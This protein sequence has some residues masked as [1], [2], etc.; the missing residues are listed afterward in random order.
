MV[1]SDFHKLFSNE[2]R[3][4]S[5]I[6]DLLFIVENE[7]V[8]CINDETI[9]IMEKYY[10]DT[11]IYAPILG[12]SES[13]VKRVS[14]CVPEPDLYIFL[15]VTPEE[16]YKRSVQRSEKSGVPLA[17]KEN[18][19]IAVEAYKKYHEYFELT[20]VKF[21]QLDGNT[22]AEELSKAIITLISHTCGELF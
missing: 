6:L 4:F 12:T 2:I 10:L 15:D 13:L 16:A 5:F 7:L 20:Q 14:L 19:D 18:Y 17:P 8:P 1:Q 11:L 22:S 3:T 9:I 21:L